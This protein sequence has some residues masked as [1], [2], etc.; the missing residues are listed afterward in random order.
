[1][2]IATTVKY[3]D[4]FNQVAG[5]L[6]AISVPILGSAT[7]TN[8]VSDDPIYSEYEIMEVILAAEYEL[9]RA[10]CSTSSNGRKLLYLDTPFETTTNP[11]NV[12]SYLGQIVDVQ[13]RPNNGDSYRVAEPAN[14]AL[15]SKL[16]TGSNPLSLTLHNGL[17]SIVNNVLWFTGY[18]AKV[19]YCNYQKP[20]SPTDAASLATLLN[21]L[22]N[23]PDDCLIPVSIIAIAK[24]TPKEGSMVGA[25]SYY[26]QLAQGVIQGIVDGHP[27]ITD[28]Q[29][30]QTS[31]DK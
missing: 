7:T 13:I 11:A 2:S 25:A 12:P 21:T 14:Q 9:A 24:I 17:Y 5:S 20:S 30:F 29:Q 28:F 3:K 6:N 26:A 22:A 23:I 16:S 8:Q 27:P 19:R 1:M 10:I 4:I 18:Q 15:I 31:A